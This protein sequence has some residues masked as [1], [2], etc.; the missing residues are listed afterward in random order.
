MSQTHEQPT[1]REA[2][3]GDVPA[4]GRIR[5]EAIT[6]L[7][8]P[9]LGL[10]AARAWA[11]SAA[12]DR[13]HRAVEDHVVTVA[14]LG[15]QPIGWVERFNNRVEGLYV[16]PRHASRGVGQLLMREAEDQIRLAGFTTMFLHASRNAETFY[17][18]Y[19]FTATGPHS[20][21]EGLP[22]MKPLE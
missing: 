17:R 3:L 16:D 2:A 5:H 1:L 13:V 12:H 4:L 8:A 6:T 22:M 11:N 21:A 10:D 20:P 19:G 9:C 7:A 14:E 15:Q 18:A